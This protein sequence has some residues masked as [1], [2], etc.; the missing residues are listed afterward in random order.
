M[1]ASGVRGLLVY[2]ADYRCS[3]VCFDFGC[4]PVQRDQ[5]EI[6]VRRTVTNRW[7]VYDTDVLEG[8]LPKILE[9][10]CPRKRRRL[11]VVSIQ[12]RT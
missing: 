2:C 4:L 8:P 3:L 12:N 7:F 11:S 5:L 9:Q 10:Q 6:T 1:R